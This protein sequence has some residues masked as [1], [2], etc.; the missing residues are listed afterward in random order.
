MEFLKCRD[1]RWKGPQKRKKKTDVVATTPKHPD[2]RIRSQISTGVHAQC[3]IL[4]KIYFRQSC[5]R[6]LQRIAPSPND[7]KIDFGVRG[8]TV[9]KFT[10]SSTQRVDDHLECS[11]ST[12]GRH[13]SC[14]EG[15]Q[16]ENIK[17]KAGLEEALESSRIV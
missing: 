8:W 5:L 4:G 6:Q 12:L 11:F 7:L 3:L 2:F 1:V 13:N 10:D 14:L 16:K 15:L 9:S 17:L